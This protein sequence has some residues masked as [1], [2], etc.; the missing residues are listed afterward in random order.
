MKDITDKI[1]DGGATS[2]GRLPAEEYNDR[3]NELETAV[4][5]S[6][7]TLTVA[8][9]DNTEQLAEA[10]FLNATKAHSF[11]DVGAVNAVDLRPVSGAS[12]VKVP[13]AYSAAM[14]G[15]Q[16]SFKP[17]AANTGAT[18]VNIG[19]T[20]GIGAKPL[21]LS[22]TGAA[23]TGGE[24]DPTLVAAIEYKQSSDRWELLPWAVSDQNIVLP[25]AIAQGG[26]GQTTASA[27]RNALEVPLRT[28]QVN[29]V[30]PMTQI[31]NTLDSA[32]ITIEA[33]I[34][35]FGEA[36]TEPLV[37]DKYMT[38]ERVKD[39]IDT[40]APAV[41]AGINA[42][43]FITGDD[44][45]WSPSAGSTKFLI[46]VTGGGG[47]GGSALSTLSVFNSGG[48]GGAGESRIIFTDEST[49]PTPW[50]IDIGP[51]G[52][53]SNNGTSTTITD[54]LAS[55]FAV[56]S[57]GNGG[58]S[59]GSP[60]AVDAGVAGT[61]GSGGSG[62]FGITGGHGMGG[63]GGNNVTDFSFSGPSG[64][65]SFWGGGS[66]GGT[67]D[68]SNNSTGSATSATIRGAGGGAGARGNDAGLST[69]G[70]GGPGCVL[71]IEYL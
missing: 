48:S 55:T 47:G 68:Y 61:G 50:N 71:I 38:P 35:S 64:G 40:F 60:A 70:T 20:A 44:P 8:A 4:T 10:L 46:I 29:V 3:N 42:V 14:D 37:D 59:G 2:D 66:R 1:N 23:L 19:Q 18:T 69:G 17:S 52:G 41:S 22:S 56:A 33:P 12:G 30:A 11:Q 54:N 9:G 49:N 32:T 7:Q 27:A 25:L 5:R 39:A 67:R 28:N 65:A 15:V 24:L 6:G 31:N 57:G 36:T 53:A 45:S 62:G 16:V 58:T 13:T 51:G 21:V 43:S 26:T 63:I 34:A